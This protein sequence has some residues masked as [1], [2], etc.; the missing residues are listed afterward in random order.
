MRYREI[1]LSM[2]CWEQNALLLVP[3]E[4]FLLDSC[5]FGVILGNKNP[6]AISTAH[7]SFGTL[8]TR[9]NRTVP[10]CR[11]VTSLVMIAKSP[12]IFCQF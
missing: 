9:M 5:F 8:S 10:Y 3:F 1:V 11:T 6:Y 7:Q 2:F 12:P 4:R